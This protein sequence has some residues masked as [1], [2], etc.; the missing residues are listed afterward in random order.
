MSRRVVVVTGTGSH[1][2]RALAERL[3][4]E[5]DSVIALDTAGG[6]GPDALDPMD[7]VAVG[8]VVARVVAQHGRLDVWVNHH[9]ALPTGSAASLRA[10]DLDAALRATVTASFVC[11]QAVQPV[12]ARAGS[13]VIVNI[14]TVDAF[15]AAEGRL[16]I[17]VA[18]AA[19]VKLTQALGVEWAPSG[20]RVVGVATG[21]IVDDPSEVAMPRPRIPLA[22]AATLDEVVDAIVHL[23][24]PE[25]SY[26]TGET[27]RVDGGWSAYQLF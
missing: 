5:G 3:S 13:G 18:Q 26:V 21:A 11:A 22:R 6:T 23:A 14:G 1:V 7:A 12:M 8:G 20:V 17:G 16:A 10:A 15:H 24:G 27:L 2:V 9:E 19:L 4:G 25:A